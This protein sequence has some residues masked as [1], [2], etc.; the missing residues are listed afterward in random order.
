ME[1]I[2][3]GLNRHWLEAAREIGLVGE[4]VPSPQVTIVS[5][6]D[7]SRSAAGTRRG[8]GRRT[9]LRGS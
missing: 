6:I 8:S 2:A 7:R 5:R 1:T 9:V 3:A 4:Q